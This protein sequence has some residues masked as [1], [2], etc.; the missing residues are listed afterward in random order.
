[1]NTGNVSPVRDLNTSPCTNFL[2]PVEPVMKKQ[3]LPLLLSCL[4][5]STAAHADEAELRAR[6]EKL[7]AELEA[8]K[9]EMKRL[10]RQTEAVATQQEAAARPPG[11]Q[12][13]VIPGP[14]ATDAGYG[15]GAG[16]AVNAS[17]PGQVSIFGYGEI[18]YNRP[19]KD[20]S[21]T[22]ADL[23]R[24]VVGF[25]Y[26]FNE[27]T[28]FVSEF[29]WEHA[30]T[31][32]SDPGE[33]EVEQF[34]IDHQLSNSVALKAGLF[35][36][37]SGLLNESHEPTHYYGVERNFV[38]TAIIPTTWREGGVG[39]HGTT[40]QGFNWDVGV[41]TGFNLGKWGP[42]SGEGRESPLGS[43]HQELSLA[44][45]KDLSTY[46]AL[47]YLGLP[48]LLVGGSVFTGKAGQGTPDFA[49]ADARV[50]LW[51]VHARWQ[52]GNWDLSALYARGTISDTQQFNL[53]N[54]GN[55]T[56]I[57]KE[58]FGWYTQAAYKVWQ[59][60]DYSLTPFFRY[61]RFN[62]ASR[63]ASLPEGLS[64]DPAAT[65]RVL[66]YGLSF[67]LNPNVVLKTDYQKFQVDDVRDRFNLGLGLM[68]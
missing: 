34:F 12:N 15:N 62:T 10:S 40:G 61:E 57:P 23:R 49:A 9:S 3:V 59:S 11:P 64:V 45:A 32:A 14:A 1:M 39:L 8:L 21:Q 63:Y 36:I 38:E 58:F 16:N 42:A 47:N 52:P 43:I 44:K 51:D 24:A 31:S 56:P 27:Q 48:G 19:R 37:P 2:N 4:F 55:P 41:T 67:Y 18:N 28:R 20:T 17:A 7:S 30:V 50:T 35:L 65:E 68:F 22:Q 33:S 6:V 66:T 25:G 46:A 60:G 26:R 54:I 29:E 13:V 53:I 5:A